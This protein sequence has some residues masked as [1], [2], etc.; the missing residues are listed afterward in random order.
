MLRSTLHFN[1]FLF[2]IAGSSLVTSCA[3]DATVKDPTPLDEPITGP[4]VRGIETSAGTLAPSFTAEEELY[5]V[6][7]EGATTAEIRVDPMDPKAVITIQDQ[8]AKTAVVRTPLGRT[9][10]QVTATLGERSET[11]TLELDRTGD[12]VAE[13]PI[14]PEGFPPQ[15]PPEWGASFGYGHPI[16]SKDGRFVA[17]T[18]RDYFNITHFVDIYRV[19]GAEIQLEA[20]LETHGLAFGFCDSDPACIWIS[21][22][23]SDQPC[24][25]RTVR[26]GDGGW[27]D[28]SAGWLYGQFDGLALL[29]PDAPLVA[30]RYR[31]ADNE[32]TLDEMLE[33][34]EWATGPTLPEV[35]LSGRAGFHVVSKD[36]KRIV[37][38][39]LSGDAPVGTLPPGHIVVLEK[40]GSGWS[41]EQTLEPSEPIEGMS[42][43][44][45]MLMSD[46]G[47]YLYV[48]NSFKTVG[49]LISAGEVELFEWTDDRYVLSKTFHEPVPREHSG[50]GGILSGDANTGRVIAQAVDGRAGKTLLYRLDDPS[51][52][53]T[54]EHP[55]GYLAIDRAGTI[56][57][58]V[59]LGAS[60]E[61]LS[62]LRIYR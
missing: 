12:F 54:V 35:D 48:G 57:A 1:L 50:F 25:F 33:G 31:D 36:R 15:E 8:T 22:G 18:F 9:I 7:F 46:D 53:P 11:Y 52:V 14:A 38:S 19:D 29:T 59:A 23:L 5:R 24:E 13:A 49:G 26:R 39:L 61:A 16:L 56:A 43:G 6:A 20:R 55:G 44:S 47:R 37:H 42:Y 10:V 28:A 4:L 58:G 3:S 2:A 62:T 51:A 27:T 60:Q 17:A 34:G 30:I 32:A 21:E 45:T 41:H 40:G